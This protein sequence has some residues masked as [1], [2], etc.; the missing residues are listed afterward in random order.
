MSR[1]R[2]VGGWGEVDLD[3][4]AI[5]TED[6]IVDLSELDRSDDQHNDPAPATQNGAAG[7]DDA[8]EAQSPPAP[9]SPDRTPG[10]TPLPS[11]ALSRE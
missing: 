7:H 2:S 6:D 10:D 8:G 9:S 11:D 3:K 4:R 5:T 1:L